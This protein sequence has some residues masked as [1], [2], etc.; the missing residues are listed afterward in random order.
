MSIRS[1]TLA[2]AQTLTVTQLFVSA[3]VAGMERDATATTRC[4]CRPSSAAR[5]GGGGTREEGCGVGGLAE[6]RGLGVACAGGERAFPPKAADAG[7]REAGGGDVVW[8]GVG[9]GDGC[10]EGLIE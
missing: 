10:G 3:A 5:G 6:G 4:R 2:H 9:A 1:Q 7:C 8:L